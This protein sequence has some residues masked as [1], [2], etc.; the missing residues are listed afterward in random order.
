MPHDPARVAEAREWLHKA[1]LDLRGARIDLEADPPLVE[2]S[3]FHC[4]QAV[5]KALKAFL[6]WHDRPF[7][8]THSL[9]ELGASCEMVDPSL[10]AA[11]DAAVPLTEFAWAFR[12]PGDHPVPAL[13]DARHGLD[14]AERTVAAVVERLPGE[15]V[16]AALS[17][18]IA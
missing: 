14:T 1:S 15:A 13:E 5:E 4:Q 6:A 8:K 10:Q 7:R 12:Y 3:L 17:H 9:E 16:P 18:L 11:V 2:D